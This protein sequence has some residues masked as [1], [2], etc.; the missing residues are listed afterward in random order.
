LGKIIQQKDQK[1]DELANE[2]AILKE[3][4]KEETTSS[5][6]QMEVELYLVFVYFHWRLGQ[7]Y[8]AFC[9][10][11]SWANLFPKSGIGISPQKHNITCMNLA[12]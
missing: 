10:V 6:D 2:I 5:L 3:Q 1:L 7:I 8:L 9:P 11:P 12:F 4:Q